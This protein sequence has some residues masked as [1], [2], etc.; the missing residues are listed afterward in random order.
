MGPLSPEETEDLAKKWLDGSL[1]PAEE[2][3]FNQWYEQAADPLITLAS[4][5]R[6]GEA[7]RIRLLERI[8]ATIA[9]DRDVATANDREEIGADEPNAG[10][11]VVMGRKAWP[12][13]SAVAACVALL[14]VGG[15]LWVHV[16][17]SNPSGHVSSVTTNGEAV[18][19]RNGARLILQGG[20]QILLDSTIN[21]Q[22]TVQA[23]SAVFNSGGQLIYKALDEKPA[24]AAGAAGVAGTSY[25]TLTT[26]RGK[27]YQLLL[28]DG[29]RVWLNASS[30]ITY[31]TA[32]NGPNGPGRTVTMIGEAYFEVVHRDRMPF[33]VRV[34]NREI[35]DLGTHFNVNAYGE[36]S[37]LKTTLLEGSVRVGRVVLQPGE[38]ASVNDKGQVS[39]LK[40]A[41]LEQAVAW[42]NGMFQFDHADLKSVMGE[43]TRWYNVDVRF[44]GN[45]ASRHFG[46]KISR[47]SN[48]S[49]VLKILELSKV[50]FRIENKTIVVMP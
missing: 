32:F 40:D 1:T 37:S 6:D 35:E 5:D 19:G 13:R 30:S 28:P 14:G 22:V 10:K 15:W 25:N 16:Q 38:Q 34:R 31:P 18:R 17:R 47:F 39:V 24:G 27:Q 33:K 8:K 9:R 11:V 48:I 49:E 21:G 2:L 3:L 44:E 23:N 46:G 20:Q 43:L 50:H 7:F 42:K 4:G 41:D 26:D 45:A 12:A 36:G 29:T